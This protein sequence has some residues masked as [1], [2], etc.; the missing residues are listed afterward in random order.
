M[1]EEPGSFM[2][3]QLGVVSI[4][5]QARARQGEETDQE[6]PGL[7]KGFYIWMQTLVL[8]CPVLCHG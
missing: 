1:E 5:A 2:A 6:S 7:T 8:A 4:Q 3:T